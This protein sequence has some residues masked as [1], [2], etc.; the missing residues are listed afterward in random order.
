MLS[1]DCIVAQVDRVLDELSRGARTNA[2]EHLDEAA[3][4]VALTIAEGNGKRSP[5]A[6]GTSSSLAAQPS[7]APHAWTC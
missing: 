2:M 5:I 3:T 7:S 4:C 6:S 1:L